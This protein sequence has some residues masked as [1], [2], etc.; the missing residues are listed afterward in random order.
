[1][2]KL[3]AIIAASALVAVV[4]AAFAAEHMIVQKNKKFSVSKMKVKVGDTVAFRNDDSFFH[5]IFS[6]SGAQSFDLGSYS[7][8][9]ARSVTFNKE[10]I[11][12]VECAIHPEMKMVIEVKK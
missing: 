5:N 3:T 6:L 8:G 4:G 11:I 7:N 2:R 12:E 9:E 10:G 1:M